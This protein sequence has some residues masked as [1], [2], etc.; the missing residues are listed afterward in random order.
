M[1]GW[2]LF[3]G[4]GLI[5]VAVFLILDALGVTAP[6]T[7]LI[8]EVSAFALCA[9]LVLTVFAFTSL[10]RWEPLNVILSLALLFMIFEKN[11]A[12]LCGRA[13][14]DLINNWMLLLIAFLLGTGIRMLFPKRKFHWSV[15]TEEREDT[16][17]SHSLGSSTVYVDS[18]TM[19]P[20]NVENNI[21]SCKVYFEN[22]EGYTGNGV[23]YVENNLGS[24][25]I[26]VPQ[27]WDVRVD[28]ENNLGSVKTP[29][30]THDELPI[31]TIK[32]EN[33]LGEV[34]VKYV[35]V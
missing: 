9:G 30:E 10:I 27:S 7:E 16:R 3:L 15:R 25:V 12:V 24:L 21:G 32:G 2:K 13:E 14:E 5:L 26:C 6:L 29:N 20:S 18:A 4:V 34:T 33:N 31:L 8:G 11:I 19:T 28:V 23:L 17:E 22:P 1:K 35:K